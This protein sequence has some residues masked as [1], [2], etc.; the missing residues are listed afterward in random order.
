[1]RK[2]VY[3]F[4][5]LTLFSVTNLFGDGIPVVGI[6]EI[7]ELRIE[8]KGVQYLSDEAVYARIKL[9]PG[10]V[11]DQTV[12]SQSIR[13]LYETGHFQHIEVRVEDEGKLVTFVLTPRP[14]IGVLCFRGNKQYSSRRLEKKIE[15]KRGDILD[16]SLLN[17][18]VQSLLTYY[19]E[20]GYSDVD[21]RYEVSVDDRSGE[22]QVTFNVDEGGK[23]RI[24]RVEFVGNEPI[25]RSRLR[26]KIKT[27]EWGILSWAT[28]TGRYQQDVLEDDLQ[29]LREYYRDRG[30]LDVEIPESGVEISYPRPCRMCITIHIKPGRC[31]AYG[32][33]KISGNCLFEEEKLCRLLTVNSG[34][35]FSPKEVDEDVETLR[36]SYGQLGYLETY[37]IANRKP[38]VRTGRIDVEFVIVESEKYCLE[39][40]E[41]QGNSKTKSNVILRE[42]AL[43]PGDVFDLVRMKESQSRLEN[44]KFFDEVHLLPEVTPIPNRRNLRVTV[45]EA[46]TGSLNFGVS[47]SRVENVVGS[48]EISQGNFD[49]KNYRNYFQGAGQKFR[50]RFTYGK[51]VHS[52]RLSFEEPAIFDR[53]LAFGFDIYNEGNAYTSDYYDEMRTGFEV[54]LRKRV[55]EWVIGEL[56][57]TLE[58]IDIRNVKEGASPLILEERGHRTVSKLGLT[59]SRDTR[60]HWIYASRGS[61]MSLS[62]QLAGGILG[63]QTDYFQIDTHAARWFPLCDTYD[64]V[65]L[66]SGRVGSIMPYGD[67]TRI[68]LAERYFLGGPNNVRGFEF[69][70]VGPKDS[71]GEALGGNSRVFVTSEYSLQFFDPVRFAIFYDGGFVNKDDFDFTLSDYHDGWGVGVRIFM[72]GSLLRFDYAFPIRGERSV[73]DRSGHFHFSA[74]VVF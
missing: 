22:A 11:Y 74:G 38:N 61:L 20:K 3:I 66:V 33:I 50:L 47:F 27:K 51:Y 16:E 12:S 14:K 72:M 65:L 57:Y 34:N 40:I 17:E 41:I 60:D 70:K 8:F 24:A 46:K 18:D 28:G 37:V 21:A 52:A 35:R 39:S 15:S 42:L 32:D 68:P 71:Q 6:S 13:S 9:K 2:R 48:A 26:G 7:E 63:A 36:D 53:E 19:R 44:T 59:F 55:Y 10:Q 30:Y 4:F 73:I 54:H 67:S 31:Y 45:K 69:K 49:I 62:F 29:K 64:Q 56:S 23:Y 5:V 1:M 25:R 43:A 58:R